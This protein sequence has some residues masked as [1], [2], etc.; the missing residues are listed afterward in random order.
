MGHLRVRF[1]SRRFRY[2][3]PGPVIISL[4]SLCLLVKEFDFLT[5]F[6]LSVMFVDKNLV[7]PRLS[8]TNVV[9]LNHLLRSEIL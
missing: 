3:N 1:L 4:S 2:S 9:A 7:A 8:F 5:V 6:C